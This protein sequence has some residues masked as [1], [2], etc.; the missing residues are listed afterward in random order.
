M[1]IQ[2]P[3][4]TSG[5]KKKNAAQ[6]GNIE[7]NPT[8]A[9]QL[10]ADAAASGLPDIHKRLFLESLFCCCSI[11]LTSRQGHHFSASAAQE[12]CDCTR[13]AV[14]G[15]LMQQH[16]LRLAHACYLCCFLQGLKE[17]SKAVEAA[18][19]AQGKQDKVNA[20]FTHGFNQVCCKCLQFEASK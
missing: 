8:A 12:G 14:L 19:A 2:K 20:Q 6:G 13:M 5:E 1:L 7:V 9:F 18:L 16:K 15:S 17:I 11:S 4:R 10:I 3:G